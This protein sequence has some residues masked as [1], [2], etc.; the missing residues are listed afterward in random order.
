MIGLSGVRHPEL[1]AKAAPDLMDRWWI[2]IKHNAMTDA[3]YRHYAAFHHKAKFL[4][5]GLNAGGIKL[6]SDDKSKSALARGVSAPADLQLFKN[7]LAALRGYELA[8]RN[9]N[10]LSILLALANPDIYGIL[11]GPSRRSHVAET[12][13]FVRRVPRNE[14]NCWLEVAG[15]SGFHAR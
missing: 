3:A 1:Y 11:S 9:L 6:D 10:E 15:L 14:V 13:N 2:Q 8:P 7:A 4:A 5:Y 12:M